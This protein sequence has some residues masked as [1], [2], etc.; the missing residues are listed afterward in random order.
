MVAPLE[1]P[2]PPHVALPAEGR[3]DTLAQSKL[4]LL[5]EMG[6]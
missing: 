5:L 6:H 2:T 1:K 3:S 4:H